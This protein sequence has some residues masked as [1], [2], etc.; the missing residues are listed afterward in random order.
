MPWDGVSPSGASGP[1]PTWI[2]W[3][4]PPALD[5][6]SQ[7]VAKLAQIVAQLMIIDDH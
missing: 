7:A 1:G 4:R 6:C 3:K 5:V 2:V